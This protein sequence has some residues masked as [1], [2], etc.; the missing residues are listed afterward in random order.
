MY[1]M[2]PKFF[3]SMCY[4]AV[5][6]AK[7]Q[8]ESSAHHIHNNGVYISRRTQ[9]TAAVYGAVNNFLVLGETSRMT[10]SK[11]NHCSKV[12]TYKGLLTLLP[13][14][15]VQLFMTFMNTF[16]LFCVYITRSKVHRLTTR[17]ITPWV[18][19]E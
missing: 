9:Q 7:K 17:N 18:K 13:E 16:L 15:G 6:S 8:W 11:H 19:W 14:P 3:N 5:R 4:T 12:Y 10:G 1:C 2:I